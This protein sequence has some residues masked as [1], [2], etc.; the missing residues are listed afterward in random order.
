MTEGS[1]DPA[2]GKPQEPT[3][4]RRQLGFRLAA[5]RASKNWTAEQAGEAAGMSKATVSRYERA[6][7]T[8][9]WNQVDQLCRA[10][11]VPDDERRELVELAKNSKVTAGWWVPYASRLADPMHLLLT[12]ENESQ[13]ISH[14]SVGVVPGLLQTLEYARAIKVSPEDELPPEEREQF[15]GMRMR[16]QQILDRATPPTY[17]VVLDEAVLHRSVGGPDVMV[18]QLDHLLRRGRQE[19][20]TIQVLPFAAGAYVAGLTSFIV[21]GGSDPALDVTFV[22]SQVGGLVLEAPHERDEYAKAMALLRRE[23]LPPEASADLIAAARTAHLKA[24][25][26]K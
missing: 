1:A 14:H 7:G 23:A 12:L 25:H 6:K 5:L 17:H 2:S 3:A 15:L 13:R 16:R 18:P 24:R 21:Y 9:R 4:R 10:Y 11:G 20:I 8:V 26:D 19:H 22:E